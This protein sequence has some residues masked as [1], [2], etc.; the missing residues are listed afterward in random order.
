MLSKWLQILPMVIYKWLAK[1][2]CE[3]TTIGNSVWVLASKDILIKKS[4]K[5]FLNKNPKEVKND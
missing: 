3:I 2:F 4:K 5:I 1:R